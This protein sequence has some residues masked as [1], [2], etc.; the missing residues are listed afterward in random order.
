MSAD[1]ITAEGIKAFLSRNIGEINVHSVLPSTSQTAKQLVLDGEENVCA[2]I[3]NEQTAGRGRMGKSFY[4]PPDSGIYMSVILRPNFSAAEGTLITTLAAVAVCRA[5]ENAMNIKP[6]IKWVNDLIFNGKKVCGIITEA[7][8][9][10]KSGVLEFVVLGIGVNIST[11][12][13]PDEL[14]NIA[15]SLSAGHSRNRLIAE[16]LEQ[17]LSRMERIGADS[18]I[19]EY[20]ERSILLGKN[21]EILRQGEEVTRAIAVDIDDMGGLVVRLD[22]GSEQTLRTGEISIRGDF[23]ND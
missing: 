14:K 23:Y 18:V 7:I 19:A 8:T 12:R 15:G 5:I 17:L 21:I 9:N 16:I 4:S 22:D 1:V 11:D 3:A 2:V 20:K 13:F 10:P 6:K